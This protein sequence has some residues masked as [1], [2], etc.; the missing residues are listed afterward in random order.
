MA[1]GWEMADLLH[2]SW[3][4]NEDRIISGQMEGWIDPD[5]EL[6]AGWILNGLWVAT[7]RR[8]Q[9]L[10]ELWRFRWKVDKQ[11]E[12]GH[13]GSSCPTDEDRC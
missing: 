4:S 6:M 2:G 3:L 12:G 13:G 8:P 7:N 11:C 9:V 10:G 5:T 1:D